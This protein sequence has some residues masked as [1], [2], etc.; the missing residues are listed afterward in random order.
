M[1]V[2]TTQTATLIVT[3]ALNKATYSNPAAAL[4]T[5]AT[6]FWLEEIKHDI[7]QRKDW[8]LYE[9]TKVL[10]PDAY[11]QRIADPVDFHKC[12]EAR[13]Y[14]GAIKDTLQT[15]GSGTIT[16]AAGTGNSSMEGKPIFI[17]DGNAKGQMTRIVS[18]S[19]DVASVSP[20]WGTTPSSGTYMIADTERTLAYVPFEEI[21]VVTGTGTPTLRFLF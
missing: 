7:S 13:F 8:K 20:N 9:E 18:I 10:I 6:N 19:G 21:E 1:A 2:P 12:L 17:T 3:E 4:I 5:R 16:L 14:N 11:A 15:A